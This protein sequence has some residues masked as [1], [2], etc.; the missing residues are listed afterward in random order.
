MVLLKTLFGDLRDLLAKYWLAATVLLVV[1]LLLRGVQGTAEAIQMQ[2][3]VLVTCVFG[4][5]DDVAGVIVHTLPLALAAAFVTFAV[6]SGKLEFDSMWSVILLACMVL[7]G[8]SVGGLLRSVLPEP[9]LD[10]TLLTEQS[11]DEPSRVGVAPLPPDVDT[12]SQGLPNE[13]GIRADSLAS[14]ITAELG[15]VA[16][17]E[18]ALLQIASPKQDL[19][20]IDQ[21]RQID[22]FAK[23]ELAKARTHEIR[24]LNLLPKSTGVIGLITKTINQILG[25]LIAYQPRLFCAAVIAGSWLGWS[26]HKKLKSLH[27]RV[28]ENAERDS[29]TDQ[30][31]SLRRAA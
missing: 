15:V 22:W 25:F 16:S 5:G 6:A 7:L 23:P 27:E 3:G 2:A 8:T 11:S 20:P 1:M 31:V 24:S 28:V 9:E 10:E 29:E 12:F 18:K 19:S 30:K 14:G 26:W 17:A 4:H 21:L 13:L